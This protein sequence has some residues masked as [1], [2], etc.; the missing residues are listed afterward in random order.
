MQLN[1]ELLEFQIG[2]EQIIEKMVH[3]PAGK[4]FD[5]S[6][7]DFLNQVSRELMADRE[8]KTYSDIATFAFWI[9]RASMERE[10]R[11]FL[12]DDSLRMGRGIVFHI[13]PSNVAVNYAYSFAVGFVLGN[14]N[15]VR[16]PSR[17]FAQVTIINRAIQKVLEKE[18]YQRW[19]DYL[20]F[21]RYKRNQ[22][23]ND[24]FSSICDVRIIWGGDIAVKEIRKSEL[25]P[26][27]SEITFADRYSICILDAEEYLNTKE[28]EKLVLDFYN[29]TYLM[30]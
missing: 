25:Q 13:A 22:E 6:R 10:K 16:L 9:R 28:K 19:K 24:Y 7:I 11:A 12:S 20:V 23:I 21:M 29:D 27:A 15:I 18:N 30:D 8:T 26:R 2:N 3:I 14:A 4:P 5:D 17:P 1:S